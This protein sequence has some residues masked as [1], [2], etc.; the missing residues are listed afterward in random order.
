MAGLSFRRRSQ[1]NGTA[2][3]GMALAQRKRSGDAICNCHGAARSQT[4]STV[5]FKMPS[6]ASGESV[7]SLFGMAAIETA[8]WA[9]R[10]NAT[11]VLG[12]LRTYFERPL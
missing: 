6:S 1:E 9:R 5:P 3:I 10:T 8:I 7:D 4:T 2:F 12:R 11:R